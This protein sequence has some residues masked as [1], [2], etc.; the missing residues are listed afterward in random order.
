MKV[1]VIN[2][3]VYSNPYQRL[4][5]SAIRARYRIVSGSID[6][7]I[8]QQQLRKRSIYHIHWEESLFAECTTTAQA[9]RVRREYVESLRR[10]AEMGGKIVWTLHN[11]KPHE[12]RF[13]R[14]LFS[15]RKNLA[16]IAHSILVHNQA[17][18]PIL[19]SQSGLT[20][21]SKVTVL[22]HPAYFDI[23]E[24]SARTKD[25]VGSLPANPRTLLHFGMVRAYKGIPELVRKLPAE[26]M[27][28]HR[29]ALQICGKPL[30]AD[31]FLDGLLA[32]TRSRPEIKYSLGSVPAEEVADLLRSHAGLIIPYHNVL[33]SG[34]AVLS[35]TLGVPAVAPNTSAM[36]EFYP[37]SSHHLLF[38][39]RSPNDLRRAVLAL[40]SMSKETR[41]HIARDYLKHA[42]LCR[43]E[44][45][46]K[47][48]G[49]LYDGL[50][51][52]SHSSEPEVSGKS[53]WDGISS[54]SRTPSP[55]SGWLG[56][57]SDV[58]MQFRVPSLFQQLS[59]SE[60]MATRTSKSSA[61]AM[62]NQQLAL[63]LVK[64]TLV[65]SVHAGISDDLI[66]KN[67]SH[68]NKLATERAR[69]DAAYAVRLYRNILSR[70]E[71]P[72]VEKQS[73][74]STE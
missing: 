12:W 8:A 23:Y 44:I 70:L 57:P 16:A 58:T 43:P 62:S 71:Q 53:L 51:G 42:F 14:T 11:I 38:N 60:T 18:L 3:R 26:F 33:T 24:P 30:R 45:V 13:V 21:L 10:Y 4:L 2:S 40:V 32:Q 56:L 25:L 74:D 31:S 65:G 37:A 7:A 15:L 73:P 67:V 50:L 34:V 19:Q 59:E 41:E 61:V 64:A 49:K 9:S 36:R 63:E 54:G 20:D 66:L 29:L 35:L 17:A 55:S 22:P 72:L 69:L 1:E 52:L 27:A 46:S 68:A 39:P 47:A 48:L 28:Q 5:Y 6:R